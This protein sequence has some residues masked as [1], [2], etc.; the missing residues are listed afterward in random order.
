V[1]GTIDT[2]Y[3]FTAG[4][5]WVL[6]GVVKVGNGNGQIA[7]A[8]QVASVKAAGVTLTVR[9]G[10]DVRGSSNSVLLVTRGSKLIADGRSDAPITFSSTDD[11][12]DGLGEWGG[13]I[14]QGFAPQYGVGNTGACYGSGTVCNVEGEG[15]TYVGFFGGNEPADNSGILRYVRVTESGIVAGVNNEIQ[16]ITLQGV[17]YG[18]TLDYIQIHGS[19]DDGIEWFGG[20]V[21]ATHLVFTNND[22]DDIDF[23]QGWKGNIQFAIVRKN[24]TKETPSGTNDPRAIEAN[25]G[26]VGLVPQTEGVLANITLIGGPITNAPNPVQP[27]ALFRGAVKATMVNSAIKGFNSGCVRVQDANA[28]GTVTPSNVTLTNVLGD[29]ASGFYYSGSRQA[30]AGSNAGASTVT[31]DAAIA[32]T[33]ANATLTAAPTITPA[34]SGSSFAF[35]PTTYV[36]AVAPGTP[37][38]SAWWAGWTIPGSVVP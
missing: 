12:F 10:V 30:D 35:A 34:N 5:Q 9:P 19:L 20:T 18:T 24:P 37:A 29:C 32:M 2:N 26:D 15:G 27:G 7:D 4:R 16:G 38:A 14:L 8:A 1:T 3:T 11:N 21:N 23:D 31:F 25:T 6:N 33:E 22:D 13:I 28:N 17:G 36:G